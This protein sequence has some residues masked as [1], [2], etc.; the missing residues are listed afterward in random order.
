MSAHILSLSTANPPMAWAQD[1][2]AKKMIDLFSLEEEKAISLQQMYQNSAIGYRYSV[3]DDSTPERE[4][5]NFFGDNAQKTKPGMYQRNEIYKKEAPVFAHT[6][7]LKAIELWGGSPSEITHVISVSCTGVMAPGIEFQLIESL[8]LNRTVFRLGINFMGCFGAFKGLQAANAFAK[9]CPSHRILL[10]CTELCSLHFQTDLT[11]DILLANTLFSDGIAAT[12]VGS[13]PRPYEKPLFSI[14]AQKSL[15][16]DNSLDK[17]S[18]EAGDH[19]F[20]MKLSSFV[21]AHIKKHIEKLVSPL[22][23]NNTSIDE[24]D[25][26]VHPGGKSII[27][28]I[29]RALKL[30][31]KQTAAAWE[32]LWNY[33][34]MSSAT[35]LFVL[36]NIIRC[37][38]DKLWTAGLG[39][40]PGLSLEGILLRKNQDN[41]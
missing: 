25:W 17:M 39:F 10:V 41:G 4:H 28:A 36:D 31:Q 11:Q 21:P 12:V 23:E 19:G 16:I 5:R 24:C 38:T 37:K 26:A 14:V 7:A 32:T 18:W 40:G 1:D 6:A 15:A 33:G 30:D 13:D 35:F 29:E 20:F 22:L 34:N 2:I 27:Q 8:N 3:I 9:E